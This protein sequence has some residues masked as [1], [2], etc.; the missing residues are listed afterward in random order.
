MV[1]YSGGDVTHVKIYAK[2]QETSENSDKTSQ[3]KIAHEIDE[4]ELLQ[5]EDKSR[6]AKNL[7]KELYLLDP[8]D[9]IADPIA[10]TQIFKKS[11]ERNGHQSAELVKSDP[12]KNPSHPDLAS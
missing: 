10:P 5:F 11:P 2:L 12:K 8:D 4:I 6:Y 9:H 1:W 7:A 3:S